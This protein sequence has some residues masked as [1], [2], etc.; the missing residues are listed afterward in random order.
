MPF[1][2]R[3]RWA[4]LTAV[5]L[6]GLNLLLLGLPGALFLEPVGALLELTGRKLPG[7]AAWPAA[8][9]VSMLMPAGFLLAV[10]RAARV[11]PDASVAALILWGLAGLAVAGVLLSFLIIGL[12]AT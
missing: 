11:R 5:L 12:M 9:Y 6:V 8:I 2:R 1:F 10:M 7:D 4:E 3:V